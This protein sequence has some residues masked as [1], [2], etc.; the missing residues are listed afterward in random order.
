MAKRLYVGNLPFRTTQEELAELFSAA[1]TVERAEVIIKK[2]TGL[3]KGF[4]FVDMA[5]D[6]E[7]AQAITQYHGYELD[8]RVL[9]VNEARPKEERP[10]FDSN[11]S[12]RPFHQRDR[13]D[14][15]RQ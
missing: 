15:P 4:G 6:Q 5:T 2:E 8:G 1:G 10:A 7:A 9:V 14:H 3:S 11:R 12:G 13:F